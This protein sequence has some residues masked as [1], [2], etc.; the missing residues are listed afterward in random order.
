[1]LTIGKLELLRVALLIGGLCIFATAPA[2][3][4]TQPRRNLRQYRALVET[5]GPVTLRRAQRCSGGTIGGT[6]VETRF[7]ENPSCI[8]LAMST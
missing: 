7:A 6:V 8:W 3:S 1:M 5:A 4:V 2:L